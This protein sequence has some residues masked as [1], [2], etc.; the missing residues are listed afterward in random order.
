MTIASSADFVKNLLQGVSHDQKEIQ[1]L[2]SM[3]IRRE[4]PRNAFLLNAGQIWDKVFYLHQ[5][6]VR[7][8]YVDEQGREFNKGFFGEGQL[9]WPV[10]PRARREESL[11]SMA[12]LENAAISGC[13]FA[14]LQAWLRQ[15]G[16]WERFALPFAELFAEQ[17][18]LREYEF[19]LKSATERF[20]EFRAEY[21]ALASRIPDYHIASYLGI[22]N[23]SLSRIKSRLKNSQPG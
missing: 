22:T 9:V 3:F 5:G 19:L 2:A 1:E 12:T 23:V 10:A 15:R 11:F 21:P 6:I 4:Y 16:Y 20:R 18:F 13:R 7:L 17:K 8:F 14:D